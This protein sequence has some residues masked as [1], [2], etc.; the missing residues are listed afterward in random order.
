MAHPMSEPWSNWK[1]IDTAPKNRFI[2]LY[3]PEDE[4]KWWAAWQGERWFGVDDEG[5]SREG[6]SAGDP[7][8]VTGWAVTQWT[9]IPMPTNT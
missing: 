7:D 4:S 9:E 3:C 8:V 5:L 2:I 1:P 6:Y